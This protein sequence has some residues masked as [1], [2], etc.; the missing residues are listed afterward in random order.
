MFVERITRPNS[1]K[2]YKTKPTGYSKCMVGKG[3]DGKPDIYCDVL[4]DNFNYICSRVNEIASSK[5]M[6]YLSNTFNIKDY[7]ND[8]EYGTVPE[9]GSIVVWEKGQSTQAAI[10]EKIIDK[11][12]IAVSYSVRCGE[13]F[14]LEYVSAG[15]DRNWTEGSVLFSGYTLLRF[16]YHPD[17]ERIYGSF[18]TTEE[19]P[20]IK[21]SRKKVIKEEESEE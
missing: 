16:M 6:E 14:V 4:P 3:V 20:S 5:K 13:P 17:V 15:S 10:V 21:K 9:L 19:K 8:F 18:S 7:F 11:N 1:E 12:T 2:Y